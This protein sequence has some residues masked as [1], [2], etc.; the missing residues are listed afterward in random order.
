MST[1][2]KL[3]PKS[4]AIK[5]RLHCRLGLTKKRYL[6]PAQNPISDSD[7][8]AEWSVSAPA[9]STLDSGQHVRNN[10]LFINAQK[11]NQDVWN[12][13]KR[14]NFTSQQGDLFERERNEN[15]RLY[16]TLLQH[17]SIA[18][19]HSSIH[20]TEHYVAMSKS[21]RLSSVSTASKHIESLKK[22]HAYFIGLPSSE[23]I[24]E[25]NL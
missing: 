17:L 4:L 11:F 25:D 7:Q 22:F 21:P 6:P 20:I 10:V 16:A 19:G 15:Q 13:K 8:N 23:A 14:R 5:K 24:E 1:T 12:F 3:N 2:S 18:L 9:L